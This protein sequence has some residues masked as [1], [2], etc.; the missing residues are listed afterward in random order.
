[1]SFE[2]VKKE[3]SR[4]VRK[5][6]VSLTPTCSAQMLTPSEGNIHE[7]E[8][9]IAPVNEYG[10]FLDVLCPPYS[11][12]HKGQFYKSDEKNRKDPYPEK[13][14]AKVKKTERKV[15]LASMAKP[16]DYVTETIQ[17]E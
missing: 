5:D 14:K 1:L 13:K 8:C 11:A 16:S 2:G 15:L 7:V 3:K 9:L 17:W 6:D 12:K 10:V 4:A